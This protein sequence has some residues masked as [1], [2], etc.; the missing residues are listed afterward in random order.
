MPDLLSVVGKRW[1]LMLL[2]TLAAVAVTFVVCLLMPKQY[3]GVTTSLPANSLLSDKARIFSQN[4]EALY[5]E[6]GTAD[7]LDK[8]EGTAKLDTIYLAAAQHFSLATHY[9]ID[10]NRGDALDKAALKLRKN[11][12]VNRTGYGELKVFVWDTDNQMAAALANFFTEKINTIHQHLQTE[13]NQAIL[14]ALKKEVE[15]KKLPADTQISAQRDTLSSTQSN[16]TNTSASTLT[17]T[18]LQQYN[19]LIDEYEL[20]LQTTPNALLVV[21]RA[22]PQPWADKPDFTRALLFAF[23]GALLFSFFLSVYLESRLLSQ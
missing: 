10:S 13:N 22:R 12:L 6:V 21:E 23:L 7:E 15:R 16:S 2:L 20:A 14:Q 8:L 11:T 9:A 17:T 19:Q 1:K 4:I 5:G 18:Q 3:L